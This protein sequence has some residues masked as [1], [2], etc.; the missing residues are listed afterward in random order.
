MEGRKTHLV[1][2]KRRPCL[3]SAASRRLDARMD[4]L[5]I[6]LLFLAQAAPPPKPAQPSQTP[7]R[8]LQP[9]ETITRSL[10]VTV[11]VTDGT[12]AP[13]ADVEV[14]ATGPVTREGRTSSEGIVRFTNVRTGAYRLRFAREGF[15]T[16]E[17]EVTVRAGDPTRFDATLSAALP[18]PAP[19]PC[20]DPTK[21]PEPA[22]ASKATGPIGEPRTVG[23]P[24]F[25]EANF[26]GR[27]PRKDSRF[28]CTGSGVA[29]IVQLREAIVEQI[30]DK[31]DLW[32]YVVAGEGTLRVSEREEPLYAGTFSVIP[33]TM[34]HSVVPRGRNPLIIISIETGKGCEGM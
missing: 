18:A 20:P 22:A 28:G 6:A 31:A 29:T 34:K 17:R 13:L 27:A 23:V 30:D 16:L 9:V 25:V 1:Y 14:R 2:T 7:P 10:A 12:G 32:I 4:A 8:T 5:L 15:L 24:A 26:I 33:R 21:T 11:L 3:T 19:P